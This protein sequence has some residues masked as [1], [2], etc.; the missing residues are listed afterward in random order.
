MPKFSVD[1]QKARVMV[2]LRML[3]FA[4]VREGNHI[5]NAAAEIRGRLRLSDHAKPP[6]D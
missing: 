5:S 6:D 3:G 2:A 1:A 4:V